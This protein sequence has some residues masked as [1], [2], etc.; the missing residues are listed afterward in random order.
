LT[1]RT[2]GPTTIKFKPRTAKQIWIIVNQIAKVGW[3]C[4][5]SIGEVEVRDTRGE[6]VALL[7]RGAG[8]QVSSTYYGFGMDRFTQDM[9]WPISIRCGFIRSHSKLNETCTPA[10][11]V[12]S[13]TF[14][15]LVSRTST[16]PLRTGSPS[17]SLATD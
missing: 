8:V 12:N 17:P 9:L 2:T 13:A 14:S 10:P 1:V 11:R 7:T 6:N 5:F 16:S 3:G 4:L 15:P